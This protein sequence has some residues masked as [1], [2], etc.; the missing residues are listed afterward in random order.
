MT[1]PG[2]DPRDS[3]PRRWGLPVWAARDEG[4]TNQYVP[5]PLPR[6]PLVNTY[7]WLPRVVG[8]GI[9]LV[10]IAVMLLVSD[11]AGAVP[12]ILFLALVWATYAVPAWWKGRFGLQADGDVLRVRSAHGTIEVPAAEVRRIRYIHQGASPD[13]K[14]VTASGA[15]VF[16]ATSRLDR[17]HSTLFEWLRQFAPQVEYDKKSLEIRDRL[18][19]R[20]LIG[21]DRGDA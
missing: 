19:S 11:Q 9:L 1:I 13:F 17:G 2:T 12:A 14:L 5:G 21:D 8:S 20:G 6:T 18:A 16:V 3:D 7:Q 15:S 10:V 4:P